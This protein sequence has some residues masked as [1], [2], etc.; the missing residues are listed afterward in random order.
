MHA[1]RSLVALDELGRGTATLDGAAIAS[2]VLHHMSGQIGCRGLFATHYHHLSSEHAQDPNVAIMHMACAVSGPQGQ[3][4]TPMEGEEEAGG[5]KEEVVPE[6][7]LHVVC[8]PPCLRRRLVPVWGML[9]EAC[10]PPAL[11]ACACCVSHL[12]CTKIWRACAVKCGG[13]C[14]RTWCACAIECEGNRTRAWRAL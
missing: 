14:T 3:Q 11:R 2:A 1:H 5:G 6:G 7:V 4:H 9:H 13:S 12:G 8:G 10:R